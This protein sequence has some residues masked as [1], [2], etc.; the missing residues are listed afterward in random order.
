[1]ASPLILKIQ[2]ILDSQGFDQFRREIR[3]FN[4]N[5]QESERTTVDLQST[6]QNLGRTLVAVFAAN[7]FKGFL[8]SIIQT[9]RA[10]Q[11][12][13]SQLDLLGE[14]GDRT[15][16][17]IV[18]LTDAMALNA[19]FTQTDL[20]NAF[21]VLIITANSS[22]D[23]FRQL[24][25][26]QELSAATG[27]GL[28]TTS[29]A[30]QQA[31]L[32]LV[33]TLS[34]LTGISNSALRSFIQ[35]G[36]LFDEL[37]NKFPIGQFTQRDLQTT[38]AAFDQFRSRVSEA[39]EDIGSVFLPAVDGIIRALN[40]LPQPLLS[41]GLTIGATTALLAGLGGAFK[42][43][44][45][46]VRG[47]IQGLTALATTSLI[48]QRSIVG[49][50]VTLPRLVAGLGTLSLI[51][52][53]IALPFVALVDAIF[54]VRKE[55]E[56]LRSELRAVEEE[57]G[58]VGIVL[59]RSTE[60]AFKQFENA[61]V[62]AKAFEDGIAELTRRNENFRRSIN[63]IRLL[64][65]DQNRE[66][67]D[68]E[69]QRIEASEAAI[70]GNRQ[71][72]D[73]F[74]RLTTSIRE[75]QQAQSELARQ[76]DVAFQ[77]ER[78]EKALFTPVELR[79]EQLNS[80]A[81]KLGTTF[82]TLTE[83]QGVERQAATI[84]LLANLAERRAAIAQ[85]L[86]ETL[87]KELQIQREFRSIFEETIPELPEDATPEERSRQLD[88]L[89]DR[90]E[91][92]V[93]TIQDETEAELQKLKALREAGQISEAEFDAR[94]ELARL[95]AKK[96]ELE[97]RR[98]ITEQ[99]R[100]LGE[101]EGRADVASREERRI[102]A[103]ERTLRLE[104]ERAALAER[105]L[106]FTQREREQQISN[107]TEEVRR[108]IELQQFRMTL[109]VNFNDEELQARIEDIVNETLRERGFSIDRRAV[110]PIPLIEAD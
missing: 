106:E 32:G 99:I 65:I 66:L 22:E 27:K 82:L 98:D 25:I 77:Q 28:V 35:Q 6:V 55:E 23:A 100:N 97:I 13:A 70:Q 71:Q 34:R 68:A 5:L 103:L 74:Q 79:L 16:A 105:N 30:L 51:V 44:S 9:N 101:I 57:A 90:R 20:I 92:L 64:A 38:G 49:L 94:V 54:R 47:G 56:A 110:A 102:A 109:N 37:E 42:L 95:S 48:T 104:S 52:G 36:Q 46:L 107:L 88:R 41:A 84:G 89:I 59:G 91:L 8:D 19:Q 26:A 31:Q 62:A 39:G 2:S 24:R 21:K 76:L 11:Q 60:E 93:K 78:L 63:E 87:D 85:R 83:A 61:A 1:M 40:E 12:L 108:E 29:L 80:E 10:Q 33:I 69:R 58:N 73:S 86:V 7:Q 72:I 67:S 14:S 17:R 18:E 81:S 15:A 53:A 3:D 96:Q 75:G 4:K 45:P 43:L 50:T